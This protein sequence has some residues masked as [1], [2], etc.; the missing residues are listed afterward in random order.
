MI[1]LWQSGVP[2]MKL[3]VF[4]FD[5]ILRWTLPRLHSH[6]TQIQLAPE[7]LVAQWFI[8]IFCYTLP[9]ALT[10]RVWEYVFLGGWPAMFRV[11]MSLMYA[12]EQRMLQL[13]LEGIGLLMRDWKKGTQGILSKDV[14]IEEIMKRAHLMVITDEVL[15]QLQGHFALEM[16]SMSEAS[17]AAAAAAAAATSSDGDGGGGGSG[18]TSSGMRIRESLSGSDFVTA[19]FS[20]L[21]GAT[22]SAAGSL[23][24]G[25][26]LSPPVEPASKKI[27][28]EPTQWLLRYGEQVD[29]KTAL[30]ML[31]VRDELREMEKQVDSDK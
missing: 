10:M 18:S 21:A 13:D 24:I 29:E 27:G 15:Q 17:L 8:T 5:R 1:G 19:A 7:I 25:R 22:S 30:D 31:R 2:K 14:G 16:I 12:L 20:G 3:R 11:A 23:G 9:L 6:F 28:V 26:L 4:Q